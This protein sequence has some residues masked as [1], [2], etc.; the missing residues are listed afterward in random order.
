M[1]GGDLRDFIPDCRCRVCNGTERTKAEKTSI[2]EN[3]TEKSRVDTEELWDHI[4]LLCPT[5]ISVFVFKTRTWG[6]TCC[7]V[8]PPS[9]AHCYV[10]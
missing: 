9:N 4:Y 10:F 3:Y 1:G 2:F 8:T 6:R 7:R 5:E